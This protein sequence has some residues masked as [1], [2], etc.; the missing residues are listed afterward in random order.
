[1]GDVAERGPQ[2]CCSTNGADELRTPVGSGA[3]PG[4]VSG[5]GEGEGDGGVEGGAEM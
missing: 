5:E 4:K 1:V 2:E 3:R